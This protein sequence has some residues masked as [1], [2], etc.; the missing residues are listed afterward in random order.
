MKFRQTNEG[1]DWVFSVS[2][3]TE[4][5]DRL[6][7][8]AST[9]QSL[10]PLVRHGVGAIKAD[11]GIP[12]G[13]PNTVKLEKDIPAGMSNS[14]IQLEWRRIK[15]F[16]DPTANIHNLKQPQ[17]ETVWVQILEA[18]HPSEASIL[19]AMKDGTLLAEYPQLEAVLGTLGITDYNKPVAKKK[20]VTKKKSAAQGDM[21]HILCPIAIHLEV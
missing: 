19:T 4:Q 2:S 7:Q 18:V 17:R 9:N 21:G 10:V 3:S 16:F 1:F 13:M 15:G 6:K 20:R 14:T 8:W 11:W 12:E 5:A